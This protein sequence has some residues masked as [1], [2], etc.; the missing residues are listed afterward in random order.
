MLNQ[1]YRL[2]SILLDKVDA[3][4]ASVDAIALDVKDI[5]DTLNPGPATTVVITA[6]L[7]I[8]QPNKE[9]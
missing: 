3:L 6:G 4:Q 7:P 8:E 5:Q 1:I 2:L 9:Q